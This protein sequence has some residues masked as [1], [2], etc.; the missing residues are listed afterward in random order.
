MASSKT[1]VLIEALDTPAGAMLARY[2]IVERVEPDPEETRLANAPPPPTA[3]P[4]D[5]PKNIWDEMQI[6]IA[7]AEAIYKRQPLA[8]KISYRTD[9]K[10]V[11][12]KTPEE[13]AEAIREAKESYDEIRKLTK[14]GAHFEYSPSTLRTL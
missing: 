4:K 8:P 1:F 11:V 7:A 6:Q 13:I 3:R 5:V 12:C 2:Q 14:S 9:E 10:M